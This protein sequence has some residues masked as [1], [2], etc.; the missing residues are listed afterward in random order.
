M[1]SLGRIAL[2]AL[3]VGAV[4]IASVL[5][6]LYLAVQG[7]GRRMQEMTRGDF[8]LLVPA[9]ARFEEDCGR[10]PSSSEGLD[11]L[12]KGPSGVASSWRG[13]Y[14]DK[15]IANDPWGHPY[16]YQPNTEGGFTLT[17]LG[18]DNLTGGHGQDEDVVVHG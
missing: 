10:Y 14:L 5:T 7:E 11:A 2:T 8:D 17:C 12:S 15:E 9:L 1:R 13:P 16:L 18:A 6:L 4:T 3:A